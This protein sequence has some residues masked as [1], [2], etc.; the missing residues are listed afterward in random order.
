MSLSSGQFPAHERVTI[1]P[2]EGVFPI[3]VAAELT[4]IGPHTLRS[5]ERS[6]LMRPV[7]TAGGVRLY[8]SNDLALVRR[9]A[10]LGAEGVNLAGI[11]RILSL[12]DELDDYRA[13]RDRP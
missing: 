2:D 13:A 5:Y 10:A 9:I 4:G 1:G 11:R 6:G 8:S 12:E 7:R 3:S